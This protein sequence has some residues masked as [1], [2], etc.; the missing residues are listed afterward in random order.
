MA[1]EDLYACGLHEYAARVVGSVQPLK[2]SRKDMIVA[3]V[4]AGFCKA[5]GCSEIVFEPATTTFV[6]HVPPEVCGFTGARL[7]MRVS[8]NETLQ[9]LCFRTYHETCERRKPLRKVAVILDEF[10]GSVRYVLMSRITKTVFK[11]IVSRCRRARNAVLA[12]VAI[13]RLKGIPLNRHQIR[14]LMKPWMGSRKTG[15]LVYDNCD[16][17]EQY[18]EQWKT[19]GGKMITLD[20]QMLRYLR[21]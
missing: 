17:Y 6:Y 4:H 11:P 13:L 19:K 5:L 7:S 15:M 12:G 2:W 10:E 1:D 20:M 21:S 18:R 8:Y 9:R 14:T 3:Y 16:V